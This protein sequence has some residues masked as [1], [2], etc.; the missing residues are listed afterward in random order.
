MHRHHLNWTVLSSR[1]PKH[2]SSNICYVF[3]ISK[4]LFVVST[5][6]CCYPTLILQLK[7]AQV[8]LWLMGIIKDIRLVVD[9]IDVCDLIHA[10]FRPYLCKYFCLLH[11]PTALLLMYCNIWNTFCLN[12]KIFG[13]ALPPLRHP[14]DIHYHCHHYHASAR[15]FQRACRTAWCLP[16][17]KK[18]RKMKVRELRSCDCVKV[19]VDVVDSRP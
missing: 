14:C 18:L 15:Q 2:R 7:I 5:Q 17:I 10:R 19:E 13:A 1:R 9:Q 8:M 4:L 6:C 12:Q 11:G 3:V 16:S